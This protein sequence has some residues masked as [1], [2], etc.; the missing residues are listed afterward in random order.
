MRY[1]LVLGS[2]Q[3]CQVLKFMSLEHSLLTLSGAGVCSCSAVAALIQAHCAMSE[4][5]F[6]AREVRA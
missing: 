5:K 3:N 6:A 1:L 4:A 2:R